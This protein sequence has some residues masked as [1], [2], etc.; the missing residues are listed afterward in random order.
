MKIEFSLKINA[1]ELKAGP[2]GLEKAQRIISKIL[3]GL[4][5]YEWDKKPKERG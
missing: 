1:V 4:Q 3:S 5:L 2:M